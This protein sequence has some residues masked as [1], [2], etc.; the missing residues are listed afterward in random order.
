MV[1]GG[2]QQETLNLGFCATCHSSALCGLLGLYIDPVC[3]KYIIHIAEVGRMTD[4]DSR[5]LVRVLCVIDPADK[6]MFSKW[7]YRYI[8]Y[9]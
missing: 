1:V 2:S 6:L 5:L 9:L 4:I 8:I 7:R 3:L